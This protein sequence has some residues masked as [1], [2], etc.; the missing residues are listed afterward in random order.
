LAA[1]ARSLASR[2]TPTRTNRSASPG[3]PASTRECRKS[4]SRGRGRARFAG[5]GEVRRAFGA[6]DWEDE[7]LRCL[8]PCG[9]SA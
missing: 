1:S 6:G 2:R 7:G 9:A 5:R 8:L 4:L 3:A